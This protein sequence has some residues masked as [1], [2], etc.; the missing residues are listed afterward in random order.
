MA[1]STTAGMKTVQFSVKEPSN[2]WMISAT[3]SWEP[4]LCGWH[5]PM[6]PKTISVQIYAGPVV[7]IM[8]LMCSIMGVLV[9]AAMR[10]VESESSDSLSPKYAPETTAPA[11]IAGGIPRPDPTAIK[12]T[13]TEPMVPHEVP[14][15]R[16]VTEHSNIAMG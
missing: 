16:E 1:S 9:S 15:A 4:L 14:V 13:P 11:V 3:A 6:R 12:A 7:I 5:Q 8:Y 2:P 10:L